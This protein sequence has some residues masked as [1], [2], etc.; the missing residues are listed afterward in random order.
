MTKKIIKT[1][2]IVV[3][4]QFFLFF[5]TFVAVVVLETI[6][7]MN[8]SADIFGQDCLLSRVVLS[9]PPPGCWNRRQTTFASWQVGPPLQSGLWSGPYQTKHCHCSNCTLDPTFQHTEPA[10]IYLGKDAAWGWSLWAWLLKLHNTYPLCWYSVLPKE[11]ASFRQIP[12]YS[13]STSN[14]NLINRLTFS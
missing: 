6:K 13:I 7:W 10:P 4:Y 8:G 14:K 9:F 12:G 3:F 11:G 1:D 2:V 5:Q